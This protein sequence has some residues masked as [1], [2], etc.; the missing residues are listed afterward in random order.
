VQ[1][2]NNLLKPNSGF[3][4]FQWTVS[5]FGEITFPSNFLDLFCLFTTV[6]EGNRGQ[7]RA[8]LSPGYLQAPAE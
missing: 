2:Q 6:A 3:I 5:P 8:Q 4:S 7:S 1:S